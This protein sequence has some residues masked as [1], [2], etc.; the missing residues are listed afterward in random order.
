[1]PKQTDE[2]NFI[3]ENRERLNLTQTELGVKVGKTGS[4]ISRY[5]C[6]ARTPGLK[7]WKKLYKELTKPL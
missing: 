4:D 5:E 7:T 1:M 2:G 3:K 6:G